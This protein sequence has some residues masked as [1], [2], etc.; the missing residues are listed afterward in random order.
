M[1]D[2]VALLKAVA[3]RKPTRSVALSLETVPD[4]FSCFE[5]RETVPVQGRKFDNGGA[6]TTCYPVG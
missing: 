2:V 5:A 4:L 6:G 3:F 1:S